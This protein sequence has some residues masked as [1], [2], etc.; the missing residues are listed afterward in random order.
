MTNKLIVSSS[1]HIHTKE[2]TSGIMLDVI[3]SLLP[4][5]AFSI[6]LFGW[7]AALIIGVVNAFM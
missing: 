1:P 4:A 7:R 5:S 6:V 2:T 3:I